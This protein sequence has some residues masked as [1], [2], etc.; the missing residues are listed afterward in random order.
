MNVGCIPTKTL[1]GSA[2][3]I[4]TARRGAEFGFR[5]QA[6]EVDWPRIRARKDAVVGAVVSGIERG[7][8][9]HPRITLIKGHAL[10]AGPHRLEVADRAVDAEKVIIAS[11]VAPRIPDVPGL[12][13]AGFLTNETVMDLDV[14]PNSLLILGGGPEGMEFGQIFH[15]LGV[16]V[17]ILQRRD[18]I[19][20]REDPEISQELAALL[21]GEGIDIRTNAAPT[22]VDTSP[23]GGVSVT[24]IVPG[25]QARFEADRILVAAGRR[26]HD[27]GEMNLKAAGVAGDIERGIEV[28]ETLRTTAPHVWAIG[29]VI[30]RMQ[31]THFAVYT[32]GLAARNALQGKELRYSTGRIPGAVFTD[33]EVASVGLTAE[34]AQA[35]GRKIK[36][37][38]QPMR[39]VGRARAMGETA[40]FVKVVVDA[41]TDELLG[42]HILAHIGADLLPQGILMM[43]TGSIAPLLACTCVHPT[44]SE[45]VKA[46]AVTLRPVESVSTATG[47]LP[48]DEH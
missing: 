35:R 13:A 39:A 25:Q 15:R 16:K 27:L 36:V 26:P 14:L 10:F 32:A 19:L 2:K 20:P 47:D 28:D 5:A 40:G 7:L 24:A 34:E 9:Q 17:T 37:G 1:V 6:I 8:H 41:D 42:M 31:Y 43:H 44:L 23:D 33:P 18:R 4:H 22:R 3:A 46:A 21:R 48:K 38:K 30:G 11:G 12:R 45:G 29:D